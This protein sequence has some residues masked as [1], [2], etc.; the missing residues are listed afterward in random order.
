M[1]LALYFWFIHIYVYGCQ[2]NS[3]MPTT[4]Y[5]I[6]DPIKIYCSLQ[7]NTPRLCLRNIT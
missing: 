5:A 1:A 6:N 3:H 2:N 7:L 4:I